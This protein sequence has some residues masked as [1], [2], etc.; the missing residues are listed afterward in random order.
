MDDGESMTNTDF[1]VAVNFATRQIHVYG[2]WKKKK[3]RLGW[4]LLTLSS[5]SFLLGP[6]P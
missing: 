3:K 2:I 6:L 4:G 1:G 5:L